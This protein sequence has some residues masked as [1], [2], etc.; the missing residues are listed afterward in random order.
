MKDAAEQENG[1]NDFNDDQ[2]SESISIENPYA[3]A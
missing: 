2:N 3:D 1:P